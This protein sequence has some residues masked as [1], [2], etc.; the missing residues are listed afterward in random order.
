M[1]PNNRRK[2]QYKR[3]SSPQHVQSKK[4][5][6]MELQDLSS[7]NS[8]RRIIR[9]QYKRDLLQSKKLLSSSSSVELVPLTLSKKGK[10][11]EKDKIVE[12]SRSELCLTPIGQKYRTP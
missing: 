10:G 3:S 4:S 8:S 7:S 1:A 12:V 11:K 5:S 9:T 2:V 6:S